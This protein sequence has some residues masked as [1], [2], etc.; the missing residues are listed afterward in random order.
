M[1]DVN[2]ELQ[3]DIQDKDPPWSALKQLLGGERVVFAAFAV[4]YVLLVWGGYEFKEGTRQ[5]TLIWPAAGL[6]LV[7]LWLAPLR[8]WP[9]FLAL[10]AAIEFSVGS[11]MQDPF[12]PGWALLFI[13]A[14]SSDAVVGAL[15][16][17]SLRWLYNE[18]QVQLGLKFLL[19]TTSGAIV[20]ATLGAFVAVQSYGDVGYL[21]QWQL[22]WA[23]NWLG[24]LVVAPVVYTWAVPARR[25]F[26]ALAL[27]SIWEVV[28]FL[29]ILVPMTLWVFAAPAGDVASVLQM[30]LVL[31]AIAATAAFRLPPR[32]AMFVVA[33][34]VLLAA[35]LG[36]RGTGPFIVDDTF[37]RVLHLQMFLALLTLVTFLLSISLSEMRI[38]LARLR[39]SES[40]YRSFID[41]STEA[42]W[43]VE[44]A[45]PMPVN[46]PPQVQRDWLQ[47]HAY[48]AECNLSFGRLDP[49]GGS[50][51]EAPFRPWRREVPWEAVFEQNLEKAVENQ[52]SMDGLRFAAT[53]GGRAR[54]FLTSFSGIVSDGHLLRIWG[55]ARDVTEI[56]DLNTRLLREQER[57]KNYARQ[58][59]TA[60]ERARRATAV[61]L[62][63]GIAQSLVGM[64]MTLEVA[65]DLAPV[66]VQVL[67][68]E[69]RANLRVVQDR[70]R[71]MIADLS[72][73]GLYELGLAPA[74][75]WLAVYFRG[76]DKLAVQ[77]DC[78]VR[79]DAIPMDLRVM[80]FKL[81]RELLRNVVKHADVDS[82][83]VTVRGDAERVSVEVVDSGRGFE[84]QMDLFGERVGG[85][86]L[87]SIADRI[88]AVGGSFNVDTAPGR[89]ARFELAFPLKQAMESGRSMRHAV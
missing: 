75:Q 56:V 51:L 31:V 18:V 57:L 11:A 5:L 43:R 62:H 36:S 2:S 17:R 9:L 30:P 32:W 39:E 27:R 53:V 71:N 68:D 60:E 77:L 21:H 80:I 22:W 41:L 34:T 81:V 37:A 1:A 47:A 23:G 65:R 59:V 76:H 12:R 78:R 20:S 45:Q 35:E 44:L 70:T 14:N 38:G 10:Q 72:P 74:L 50:T 49:T 25:L 33:V 54:T 83:R 15:V 46:L 42:V 28:L 24:S 61:D 16:A 66:E 87:W 67:I 69:T 73:P 7:A 64:A 26:P 4:L 85:F 48:V 63:D 88:S 19:A 84:W 52:Y 13:V 55:V 29:A 82:A 8:R 40:R 3:R 6:L 89:G 86:G 58:I 79:E